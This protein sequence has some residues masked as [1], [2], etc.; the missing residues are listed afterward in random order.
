MDSRKVVF[1]ETAI[2]LAGQILGTGAMFAVFALLGKFGLPV[3]W[4]G[5]IGSLLAVLN[6]FIMAICA[7]LAADK[8]RAQDVKGGKALIQMSMLGRYAV[9]FVILFAAAKSGLCNAVALVL[10]LIFVRPTLT[11]AEFFRKKGG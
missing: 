5:L 11:L 3:L 10:P 9:L 4:G 1:R 8:A 7:S 6:F 2:I